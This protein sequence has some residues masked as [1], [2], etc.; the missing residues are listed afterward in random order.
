VEVLGVEP[1]D[2][3]VAGLVPVV[4]LALEAVEHTTVVPVVTSAAVSKVF[5][6]SL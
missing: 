1:V 6:S 2:V 4:V 3:T 5:R